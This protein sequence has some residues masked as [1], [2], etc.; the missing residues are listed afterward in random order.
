METM[1]LFW[2]K[3]AHPPQQQYSTQLYNWMSLF[4]VQ[5][6]RLSNSSLFAE[7]KSNKMRFDLFANYLIDW[8]PKELIKPKNK[9]M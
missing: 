5:F 8:K 2:L 3:R 4:C 9:K 1:A 7:N 6:N